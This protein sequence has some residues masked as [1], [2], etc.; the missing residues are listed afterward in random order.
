MP[1][2]PKPDGW[3]VSEVSQGAVSQRP[4]SH[5]VKR[6]EGAAASGGLASVTVVQTSKERHGDDVPMVRRFGG[7]WLRAILVQG[8]VGAVAMMILEVIGQH[9]V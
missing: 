2:L 9:A 3:S 5:G 7:P 1:G 6:R 4:S 8:S